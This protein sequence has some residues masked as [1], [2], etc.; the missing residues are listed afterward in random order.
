MGLFKSIQSSI[1]NKFLSC[2]ENRKIE[3]NTLH[4]KYIK[5]KYKNALY[6]PEIVLALQ[7]AILVLDSSSIELIQTSF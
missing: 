7:I 3:F 1:E 5:Y 6:L 2:M 4:A